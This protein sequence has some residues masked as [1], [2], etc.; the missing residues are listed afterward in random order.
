MHTKVPFYLLILLLTVI[1]LV[2]QIRLR[3]VG[4]EREPRLKLPQTPRRRNIW[5]DLDDLEAREITKWLHDPVRGL[6]LTAAASANHGDSYIWVLEAHRPNKT[7]AIA[8]L[9]HGAHA[10][11]RFGR[12]TIKRDVIDDPRIEE[13][14]IGPLPVEA[15]TTITSLKYVYNSGR[16]FASTKSYGSNIKALQTWLDDI[17]T[18]IQDITATLFKSLLPS[19]NQTFEISGADQVVVEEGRSMRWMSFSQAGEA[20]TL[21]PQGLFF[22]ADTTGPSPKN[23]QI[24]QWLYN[25]ITYPNVTELRQAIRG[26]DFEYLPANLDGSWTTI[27]PDAAEENHFDA[28]PPVFYQ[29]GPSRIEISRD[30]GF[31]SWMGFTF[32]LAFSQVNG[33]SLYDIRLDGERIVYE[34]SLQEALAHYAGSDPIQSGTAF[35]DSFYGLGSR[36]SELLPGY[37]CPSY[38]HFLDTKYHR[39]E[40]TH[41]RSGTICIF[42]APTDHPLMRHARGSKTT[43][44]T[45]SVMIVRTIPVVG[46]YDYSIDYIFYLDGSFEV[47]VRASGYIQGAFFSGNQNYGYRVHDFLSSSI[48]DHVLNFKVDM[49]IG[50]QSNTVAKLN[51]VEK[52]ISY[53]WSP[54]PRRTMVLERSQIETEDEGSLDWPANSAMMYVVINR[55]VKNAF[56]EA[57]GYRIMPGTGIGTP[58]HLTIANSSVL[59][60]S[61][62]WAEHDFFVT[63]FKESEVKSSTPMNYLT[64]DNP[65]IRFDHYLN[66]EDLVDEDL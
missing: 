48:H 45:N 37:D 29:P 14:L 50:G 1:F 35:L 28:V 62:K 13:Y 64:P 63:K 44:F 9:D 42:E 55:D 11:T 6:N 34:L 66:G 58:P 15:S 10:P 52:E 18:D 24:V 65:L 20:T 57:R 59:L 3:L 27:E 39:L 33:V 30:D 17:A 43:S 5:A 47:K 41:S 46:N 22:K 8:F 26:S 7:D 40:K 25:N 23:W 56:G 38:S 19:A 21:L 2:Y 51:V 49:D 4:A 32:N 60:N 31:V 54:T 16:N 12:A 53:P 36:L 61:A